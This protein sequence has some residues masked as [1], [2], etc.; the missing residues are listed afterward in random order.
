[1]EFIRRYDKPP[2]LFYIDPPYWGHEADYGKG[3]FARED[4][5][6]M[7]DQ[8]RDMNGRFL[9]S[10]NDRPEVRDIFAG[11]EMEEVA[12]R[13]SASPTGYDYR[14]ATELLISNS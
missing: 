2:M 6:R 9:L 14:R 11:F 12:I 3:I 8:L 10:I 13:Y 7:A 1:M 4:F 5:A